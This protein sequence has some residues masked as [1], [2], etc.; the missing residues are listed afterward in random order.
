MSSSTCRGEDGH[1]SVG[2]SLEAFARGPLGSVCDGENLGQNSGVRSVTKG[3]SP[4][5]VVDLGRF[6][7][8]P[9]KTRLRRRSAW[10]ARNARKKCWRMGRYRTAQTRRRSTGCDQ[11]DKRTH[12]SANPEQETVAPHWQDHVLLHAPCRPL[13]RDCALITVFIFYD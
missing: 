9:R 12:D 2:R 1:D 8:L 4:R 3:T 13:V 5:A 10:A 6:G 11:A 7:E